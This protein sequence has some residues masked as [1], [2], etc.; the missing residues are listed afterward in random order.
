MICTAAFHPLQSP[1]N[2]DIGPVL[3]K[4]SRQVLKKKNNLSVGKIRRLI[5]TNDI[6]LYR[7]VYIS[8]ILCNYLCEQA[9]ALQ[10][11]SQ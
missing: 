7:Y 3:G 1:V 6:S 8:I 5:H 4:I 11:I 2:L 9:N 10:I